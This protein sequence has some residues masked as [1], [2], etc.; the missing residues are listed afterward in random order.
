[1]MTSEMVTNIT[2]KENLY[3]FGR[4]SRNGRDE[5]RISD[6]LYNTKVNE[7]IA[8]YY[9]SQGAALNYNYN[10]LPYENCIKATEW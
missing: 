7:L 3:Y 6:D 8:V 4:W 9:R 1:M 2:G 10:M 5:A